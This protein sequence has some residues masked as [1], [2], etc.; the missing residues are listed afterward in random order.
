[1]NENENGE[2]KKLDTTCK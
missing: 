2:K 1:M